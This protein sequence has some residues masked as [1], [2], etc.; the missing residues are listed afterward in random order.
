M[1]DTKTPLASKFH[2]FVH[3]FVEEAAA[4][5]WLRAEGWVAETSGRP[6]GKVR[7]RLRQKTW[8]ADYGLPR[9]DV[10]IAY[11]DILNR[12][13]GFRV[14][15]PVA[16][17]EIFL[18]FLEAAAD[19][20]L[21]NL[22][23]WH[24]VVIP[25]GE[26]GAP[27]RPT[28]HF[29]TARPERPH[30]HGLTNGFLCWVD[31]PT[32]WRSL[33]RR[34]RISGWC[35]SEAEQPIEAMRA[36]LGAREFPANL[37]HFR[38][39]VAQSY[40]ERSDAFKSGFEIEA[41]APRG[42][43]VLHLEARLG[44]EWREVFSRKIRGPLIDF[45]HRK[46]GAI[47][48]VG[49]YDEWIRRY[50]TLRLH[51]RRKIHQH[52]QRLGYR[53]LISVV[54]PVYNPDPEHL[55]AA[56]NSV[57][58]QLYPHWELCI[59]DDASTTPGV[60]T[61]LTRVARNDRRIRVQFRTEN[62][63]IAAASNEAL[64]LTNGDFIAL[65]DHDDELAPAALYFV[66]CEINRH[67]DA[68][69]IYSDE[70]K[71]DPTGRRTNPHFK[72]DWNWTLL[73]AQNYFSHLGVYQAELIREL[74]FRA[75]F[76]GSQD[77]DLLL[78]ASEKVD[79]RQI[80]HI[81][82]I[83]YHWRMSAGSAALNFHA[84]PKARAAA[85]KAVQEHLDLRQIAAR[86]E[87][88]DLEDFQRIRYE[89]PEVKPAVSII[90]PTR[91]LL[92]QLRSCLESILGKTTYPNFEIILID[93]G[94]REP[95]TLAYIEQLGAEPRVRI[96]RCDEE[97]NYGRLNNFGVHESRAEFVAFL[98]ND[99]TVVTADWL[100]EMVSRALQPSVG[101]VGARL[102]FPNG[103]IQHAGVILGAGGGE[104]A[105]HAHKCLPPGDHGYFAR[106][107]LAQELSAVTAACMLVRRS[108]Y[109]EV[110]GFEEE[111]LKVAFN[112]VDFCL[113]LRAA[114][115]RIIYT[116]YAEFQHWESASRGL[117]DT[118]DKH[119]RFSAE[120][121]YVKNKWPLLLAADPFYNPNL[122]LRDHLFTLAFPPR[123]S[124]P[125]EEK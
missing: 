33:P 68:Q 34:F 113:R 31:A 6:I 111:H 16:P 90:I 37:G 84:K 62:G 82:R 49:D 123:L 76:E 81:P 64:G 50:D 114:G 91:D 69:L 79:S 46:N 11:S 44:G 89:L 3:L 25:E 67:P 53:P 61:V 56:I 59:V 112:D 39:D 40:P 72:S 9:P 48:T 117:E 78:R 98:N 1:T 35:L 71:L 19:D 73:L 125:W 74:G 107:S 8:Q 119:Q 101:A 121:D 118:L 88:T 106:A 66:A 18:L 58:A 5:G 70:D 77:Y 122:D 80:R 65:L 24:D 20:G 75:G 85:I 55:R 109:L 12:S 41:E 51:E 43:T 36:R 32:D 57:R 83:L 21:W 105:D 38:P 47:A 60:R 52:I 63:G 116:P 15:V 99:L 96:L 22:F 28:R 120:V 124:Q 110:G 54:M 93:N 94:S 87:R 86:V 14:E 100:E 104:L 102:L 10:P 2:C 115:Y 29:L 108:V 45:P 103:R 95:A 30:F 23:S 17:G 42:S 92:A 7:A 26:T 97:F 27:T 13:S 4:T